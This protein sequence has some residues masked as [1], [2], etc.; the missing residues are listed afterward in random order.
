MKRSIVIAV[1]FVVCVA[2]PGLRWQATYPFISELK[3]NY[4]M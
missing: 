4:T 2:G 3:Q 1:G